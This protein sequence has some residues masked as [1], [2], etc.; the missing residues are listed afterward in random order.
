MKPLIASS[1]GD[2]R[3]PQ[4]SAWLLL[5][6]AGYLIVA[7]SFSKPAFY[8]RDCL[9][10]VSFLLLAWSLALKP[11]RLIANPII[12][13][14]GTVSFS[15]Y[16]THFAVLEL[17]NYSLDFLPADLQ[18]RL[19]P[20]PRLAVLL[21]ATLA[22][23]VGVSTITYRLVEVPGQNLGRRLI[24]W[25]EA[26]SEAAAAAREPLP[27]GAPLEAARPTVSET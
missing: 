6:I 1:D 18:S 21:L 17:A 3:M 8:L 7:C 16:I 26:R 23:T 4:A 27:L 22:G 13:Y 15:A 11:N 14:I 20:I 12:C 25:L 19:T 10:G 9:F 2:E 24:R 5:A